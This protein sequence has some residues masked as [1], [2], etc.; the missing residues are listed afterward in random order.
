[1]D[2]NPQKFVNNN[3]YNSYNNSSK[4]L[5]CKPCPKPLSNIYSL[6]YTLVVL[7][8][9]YLSFKCSQKFDFGTF[10]L[11]LFFAP[12]YILYVIIFKKF[13]NN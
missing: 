4:K 2:N 9:I 10:L 7:F 3:Q 8:A 13:C 1:M 11:A 5:D 12:I 6:L